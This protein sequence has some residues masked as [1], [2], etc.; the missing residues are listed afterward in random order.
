MDI[1]RLVYYIAAVAPLL[2]LLFFV[3]V[4][5][6]D[7][8][9]VFPLFHFYIVTFTSFAAAVIS[10][11]LTV[12]LGE[13][14]HRRHLLV[15]VAFAVIGTLFFTHGLATPDAI[16][17]HFHPTITWSAWLTFVGGG[18][19]FA[20]AGTS[21][22][23]LPI[24]Q[25]I[26]FTVA[27]I[28]G[29]FA[30]AYLMPEWLNQMDQMDTTWQPWLVFV[31]PFVIWSG[32]TFSFWRIWQQTKNQVDGV[33]ALVC[34]WMV[35]ATISQHLFEVWRL[36]WW[37]YHFM[38]LVSFLFVLGVLL[39]EY[40]RARQFRVLWYFLGCSL[41]LTALLAL[42]ASHLFSIYSYRTMLSEISRS[43]QFES[44][45]LARQ[46]RSL[47]VEDLSLQQIALTL[48]PLITSGTNLT[49]YDYEGELLLQARSNMPLPNPRELPE[50]WQAR[51]GES[52][53][54]LLAP[55]TP[56]LGDYASVR[57]H[58]VVTTYLPLNDRQNKPQAILAVSQPVP[59][60][61]QAMISARA[62]GL[63]ISLLTMGILLAALLVIV[64][65]ADQ[66]IITRTNQLEDAR[67]QSDKL[68]LNILPEE[69]AD[70]LKQHG[71]VMPTHYDCVTVMFTDFKNFTRI[72]SQL[73]AQALVKEL[74]YCFTAF[75]AIAAKYDLEKL[76]TIGDSY[77]CVSGIP[78]HHDNHAIAAVH[79]ALE[80]QAF[81]QQRKE[82]KAQNNDP[83]WDIRIGLHSGTLVAG[84]IGRDKFA[85]DVWG[86][87]VNVA[88]RMESA[89]KAGQINISRSTY[90]LVQQQ[91]EC[92]YRGKMAVKNKEPLEMYFVVGSTTN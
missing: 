37:L 51:A 54:T 69:I 29:Y 53:M 5:S 39:V 71:R 62:T 34:F 6:A 42:I 3:L 84:V 35:Q 36:S 83:Y 78:R 45:R 81:M 7:R 27:A 91:F 66:I 13:V 47:L 59:A 41:V 4:P 64:R 16:I 92:E 2:L 58:H 72:A 76:K 18:I 55:Q 19:L 15:S 60:L 89:S 31:I 77:M 80:I 25:V 88:S 28:L 1:K 20:L 12:V 44:T 74:D 82:Q 49:L 10:M 75:D 86:D 43:S 67:Q 9:A 61:N 30:V 14:A 73:S 48:I 70:E 79:A 87:T 65:R 24:R 8:G 57:P 32:A 50:F 63:M 40:E 68:L 23:W 46:A 90:E 22:D 33:L 56:L 38:L 85:Y 21:P 17:T 52:V 11:L 26:Y